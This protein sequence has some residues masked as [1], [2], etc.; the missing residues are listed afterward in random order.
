[1]KINIMDDWLIINYGCLLDRDGFSII[2]IDIRNLSDKDGTYLETVHEFMERLESSFNDR[3]NIENQ[4]KV[5]IPREECSINKQK[6][7]SYEDFIK[8]LSGSNILTRALLVATQASIFPLIKIL[9]L[10]NYNLQKNVHV[11][12]FNNNNPLRID[13]LVYDEDSI[14]VQI[15]KRF[16]L[17]E[18]DIRSD[19]HIIKEFF[20][21][22]NLNIGDDY[23]DVLYHII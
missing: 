17:V 20:V 23:G 22:I 13:L 11:T 1:M 9:F 7:H 15:A 3:R 6:V 5:D 10:D 16:Q 4:A 14:E 8:I 19:P 12:D 2:D 21:R 18:L